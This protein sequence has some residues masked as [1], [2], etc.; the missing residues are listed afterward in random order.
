[1]AQILTVLCVQ[2]LNEA[3]IPFKQDFIASQSQS[4]V[5][6]AAME[7]FFP[8]SNGGIRYFRY[9]NFHGTFRR[10]LYLYSDLD[11]ITFSTSHLLW[12]CYISYIW[13]PRVRD[14]PCSELHTVLNIPASTLC[15]CF[16]LMYHT[17][18]NPCTHENTCVV[19]R[20]SR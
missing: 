12:W 8:R 3:L 2:V 5:M 1:M 6:I 18:V 15:T 14:D 9:C 10:V 16:E 11:S 13:E 20:F 17:T 7:H 4:G 19:N